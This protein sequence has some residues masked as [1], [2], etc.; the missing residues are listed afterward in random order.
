MADADVEINEGSVDEV[1]SATEAVE[2]ELE[3]HPFWALLIR[4]GYEF[5]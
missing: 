3:T 5:I 1:A 2:G 4:A